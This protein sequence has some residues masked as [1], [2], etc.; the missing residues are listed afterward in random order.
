MPRARFRELA[1]VWVEEEGWILSCFSRLSFSSKTRAVGS[2]SLQITSCRFLKELTED[3]V[4]ELWELQ[5]H[6]PEFIFGF[7]TQGVTSRSPEIRNRSP[8]CSVVLVR[9]RVDVP[10]VCDFT[11]SCR[12]HAVD[13][14]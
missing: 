12:I 9:V 8:D 2:I 6:L 13:L 14:G 11:L 1:G 10:G 5:T 7:R 3:V 4:S